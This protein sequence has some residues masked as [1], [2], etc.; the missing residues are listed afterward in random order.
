MFAVISIPEK[1]YRFSSVS[2]GEAT[3]VS[4]LIL[5]YLHHIDHINKTDLVRPPPVWREGEG[6][7]QVLLD[8]GTDTSRLSTGSHA[9]NLPGLYHRPRVP[10]KVNHLEVLN[11]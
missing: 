7:V 11:T 1:L 4:Y 6:E 9:S 10:H 3:R 5:M 8:A 2:N